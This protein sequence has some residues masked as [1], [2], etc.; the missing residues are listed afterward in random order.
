MSTT[1]N[2]FSEDKKFIQ[3]ILENFL[4]EHE[5]FNFWFE[6]KNIYWNDDYYYGFF[7]LNKWIDGVSENKMPAPKLF[8]DEAGDKQFIKDVFLKTILHSEEF[9]KLIEAHTKNWEL[10]RIAL[11]DVLVMKMALTEILYISNVPVKVSMNEYIDVAKEYSTPQSGAFINGILD[12]IVT[13][14]KKENKIQKT[15]RGLLES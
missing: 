6:E 15:G 3:N 5:L 7:F 1:E 14:L 13:D 9:D 11:L 4:Y 10:D 12:R 8:R 2:N